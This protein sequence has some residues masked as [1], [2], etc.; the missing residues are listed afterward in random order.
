[1]VVNM[2]L[3]AV[4]GLLLLAACAWGAEELDK[5]LCGPSGLAGGYSPVTVPEDGTE[6]PFGFSEAIG[7]LKM[8][9]EANKSV[10]SEVCQDGVYLISNISKAEVCSQVVAGINYKIRVPV[11][12]SC[13]SDNGTE[14]GN[15]VSAT[16][17]VPLPQSNEAPKVSD[18]SWGTSSAP[19]S[20]LPMSAGS[21][22]SG[23]WPLASSSSL[24]ISALTMISCAMFLMTTPS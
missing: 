22:D 19:P 21:P 23:A 17:Y 8:H 20:A 12:I 4:I 15:V 7:A 11:E 18:V 10:S 1:M 24:A 2:H 5:P 3:T 16:I 14:T 9:L 13:N 6:L